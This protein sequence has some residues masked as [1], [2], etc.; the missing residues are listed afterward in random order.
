MK[1]RPHLHAQ[2]GPLS[3][4]PLDGS[5]IRELRIF[6]VRLE[7]RASVTMLRP[8]TEEGVSPADLSLVLARR[9]ALEGGALAGEEERRRWEWDGGVVRVQV[10]FPAGTSLYG[11]GEV[12]GPLLRNGRSTVLWN[13]DAWCYGEET[14]SL[15]QSHPCVLAVLPDGRAVGLV[16]DTFR[17]G[18]I[19]CASDGVEMQFEEEPFALY[20]IEADGPAE[21]TRALAALVGTIEMPP[22]W[23]L[24]Y[25]QCRWS[26]ASEAEV[27]SLAREFRERGIPCD[28]I[29]LDID[30][31]DRRR[32]FTVDRKR[33]PDLPGLAKE[34]SAEGIRTVA[35]L[36]PGVV[37]DER[38]ETCASGL[39]HGHF[40]LDSRGRPA[41]GRVWPG[42]CHFPDFTRAETRAWWA[43]RA[44]AF[45]RTNGLDGLWAD[46]NEP[47]VFKTPSRTLPDS[48]LHRG[49]GGGTHA[50]FHDL[51]GRL[52]AE[53]TRDGLAAAHPDR[54]PFVLSRSNHLGGARFAAAWTGDNQSRWEDLRWSIA[55]VL[56]L[57]LSGQPFSGPDVGG[58]HGDPGEELFARWFELGAY[59]PFFRG[60]SD[61][62]SRSKEPW[63]FGP[64]TEARVRAAIERRMRILPYLYTLFRESHEEGTPIARPLFF[65]DRSDAEMRSVDDAFLLGADLLVA[66]VVEPGI[67]SRSVILPRHEAGGWYAF[68][69][70]DA[71][72]DQREI[73]MPAPL[74]T[75]P[76][77]ARAG[78]IVPEMRPRRSTAGG[79]GPDLTLHVFL[80]RR[81]EARG[82]LYE[83]AG[84]GHG[85]RREEFRDSTFAAR[86]VSGEVRVET[87][88]VGAWGPAPT[89]PK[90]VPHGLRRG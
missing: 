47:A 4:G 41:R 50:R 74:G 39:E 13:T 64:E 61:K 83:D 10:P 45:V 38:D 17:R 29:W 52:M 12:A 26:Y 37:A 80:D 59:L 54:R 2:V 76:V 34:L 6:R 60:H 70:G 75:I 87:R 36:D 71:L 89:V 25:H 31:M 35:I 24:G 42:L 68:P 90:I 44:A 66:P 58:F 86:V 57:G 11:T 1:R 14:P 88:T 20:R 19:H 28:A 8:T 40:V 27:R 69:E 56:N 15:Y 43:E 49:F 67:S 30:Y 51:Y 85:H 72:L 48:A 81:G 5:G 33:F 53:A 7:S 46:M 32:V 63:S 16:A 78:S 65:A 82:R 22:L 3:G 77:L 79:F 55:M 18:A 84:D 9:P 62:E 21:A 73:E 23:A